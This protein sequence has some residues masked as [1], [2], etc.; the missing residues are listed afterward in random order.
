MSGRGGEGDEPWSRA[1]I[2]SPCVKICVIRRETG[3]CLGC[4]RT[5][6]EIAT[7]STL[8]PQERHAIM[9]EL[10][11]RAILN[12]PRRRRGRR[13]LPVEADTPERNDPGQSGN[14][15]ED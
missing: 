13:A 4:H 12:R 11:A 5:L 2:E 6:D 10:P 7:W 1:E 14:S 15:T 8:A 9:K 3:L